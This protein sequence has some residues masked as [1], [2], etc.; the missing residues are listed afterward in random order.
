MI[1]KVFPLLLGFFT[2]ILIINWSGLLPGVGTFG[3]WE[4]QTLIPTIDVAKY[5]ALGKHVIQ[6]GKDFYLAHLVYYFR[7]GNTSL[8]N[9][10]ALA[11]VSSITWLYFIFRYAGP[12]AIVKDIFGNKADPKKT[13]KIMYVLL[14]IIF[15][16]S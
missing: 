16:D 7:P 15:I 3:H 1:K 8:N 14:A 10:F 12:K 11:A 13:P 2:F 5:E 4:A 6:V 9:T